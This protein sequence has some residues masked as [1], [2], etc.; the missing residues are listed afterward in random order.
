VQRVH[1]LFANVLLF[2]DADLDVL[3]LTNDRISFPGRES[4]GFIVALGDACRDDVVLYSLALVLDHLL[5]YALHGIARYGPSAT[6]HAEWYAEDTLTYTFDETYGTFL[7][8]AFVRIGDKAGDTI[9]Q[10]KA[11]FLK[12]KLAFTHLW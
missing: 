6:H 10:T 1:L 12:S 7:L 9:V 3:P 8:R 11:E 5:V 2:L 4:V